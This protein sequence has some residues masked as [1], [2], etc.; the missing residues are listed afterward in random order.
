MVKFM[1]MFYTP[2]DSQAFETRYNELLALVERMPDVQRRQ[3]INVLGSPTGE[4]RY[5]RI[6]E[7]YY[8]D[9]DQLQQSLNSKQGQ[10]AGG[11]LA[12]FPAKSFDMMF[13]DVYEETGGQTKIQ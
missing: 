13:A 5:H 12:R 9:Y 4:A 10:E 8:T 3:V 6:L 11:D 7:V 2:A 1:I